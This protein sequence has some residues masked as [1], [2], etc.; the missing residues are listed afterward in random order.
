M[1]K[2]FLMVMACVLCFSAA[3][4]AESFSPYVSLKGVITDTTGTWDGDDDDFENMGLNFA[5]GT[6]VNKNIRVEFEI[7]HRDKDTVHLPY[8]GF[9]GSV[10]YEG[11]DNISLTTTSYMLNG[12]YDFYNQ[13][14]FT[15][16]VGLGIG[17]AKVEYENV[18]TES[19]YVSGV[20]EAFA[21]KFKA[22]KT[23]M[24]WNIALGASYKINDKVNF[25]LG[26]RYM[27]YGSFT[28]S[29]TKIETKSNEFSLG[30]RY[31]F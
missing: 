1:K 24:A 20:Y 17:M 9:D 7:A 23:K 3:V 14:A 6:N 27:D 8:D 5:V 26:Y 16:Y 31:A 4:K 13:S 21:G 25:D 2:L 19:N 11:Q 28:D 15:P 22:S 10:Y 29:E 12:Y 30:L 18:W